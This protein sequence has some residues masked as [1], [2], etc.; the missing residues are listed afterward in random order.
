MG[1]AISKLCDI[2]KGRQIKN[3]SPYTNMNIINSKNKQ[4]SNISTYSTNDKTT[5]ENSFFFASCATLSPK[6]LK[7]LK[8]ESND[9]I[10]K[11]KL[12]TNFNTNEFPEVIKKNTELLDFIILKTLGK[13][14]FG[15]VVL[16]KNKY[17][18][19]YFAIK[20]LNKAK[21]AKLRQINHTKAER[22][23][24]EKIN[25]T[26][27]AKL[28]FAFQT[29]ERLYLITDFMPGGE[30]FFHLKNQKVFNLKRTRLYICEI[31]IAI[32][33]LHKHG[34]IY[35]DLKPENILLDSEGHIKLTDFGLSKIIKE[36]D[37]KL[38]YTIC[39]TPEYLAPEILLAK[40]YNKSV[41][42]WS[43]GILLFEMLNGCPPFK[44][45]QSKR[46]DVNKYNEEIKFF[47]NQIDLKAKDLILKLLE[48]NPLKRIGSS[49][50]DSEEIKGHSFFNGINWKDIEQR[51]IKPE[52]IPKTEDN[53]DLK[54]FD[55]IFTESKLSFN[56][57]LAPKEDNYFNNNNLAKVNEFEN[58]SY[59]KEYVL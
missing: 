1:S 12:D 33:F 6:K 50:I 4:M 53:E 11:I 51:K 16:A 58:F 40:G 31:I 52:F 17:N 59:T 56:K 15:K 47:N 24:L 32:E 36:G 45:K 43:L 2:L 34:I 14:T 5:K 10:F 27:I 37:P 39:G 48:R 21:L 19:K 20:I 49:L 22:E 3:E 23:I 9:K 38:A 8:N 44:T 42:W 54:Y 41:D 18:K 26:F 28:V 35:R 30:L 46:L 55:K 57:D 7:N 29:I 13:G 25:H